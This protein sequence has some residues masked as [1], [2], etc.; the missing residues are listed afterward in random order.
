MKQ[1]IEFAPQA[2]RDLSAILKWY[3]ENLGARAALKVARTIDGKLR[4]I[5]AGRSPGAAVADSNYVR[6]VARKHVIILVM[7]GE[8]AQIVRIVHGAQDLEVIAADLSE[9]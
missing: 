8:I 9:D 5:A 7:R 6:V 4:S 1:R 2:K 3:R